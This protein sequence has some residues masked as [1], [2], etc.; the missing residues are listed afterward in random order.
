MQERKW[1]RPW[2]AQDCTRALVQKGTHKMSHT[3]QVRG[4]SLGVKATGPSKFQV[5]EKEPGEQ[6]FALWPSLRE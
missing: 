5:V 1:A 6:L 4:L 2:G 3:A